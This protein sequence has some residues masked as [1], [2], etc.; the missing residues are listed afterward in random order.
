MVFKNFFNSF[1]IIIHVLID[2]RKLI[3]N[4]GFACKSTESVHSPDFSLL[5]LILF[6]ILFLIGNKVK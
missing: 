3:G 6:L 1:F 2:N 5:L 4:G